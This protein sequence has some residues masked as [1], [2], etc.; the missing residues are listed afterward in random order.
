MLASCHTL[1][2]GNLVT[3]A[4]YETWNELLPMNH[5]VE[6]LV[7]YCPL[8]FISA[9]SQSTYVNIETMLLCRI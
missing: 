9:I 3:S 6:Y 5:G 4:S 7:L 8:Y 1:G 2:M